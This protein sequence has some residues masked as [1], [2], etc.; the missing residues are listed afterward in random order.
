MLPSDWFWFGLAVG[1]V[2]TLCMM[3]V[4]IAVADATLCRLG[5]GTVERDETQPPPAWRVTYKEDT[6]AE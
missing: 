3:P 4:V 6:D 5:R 1:I 2:G